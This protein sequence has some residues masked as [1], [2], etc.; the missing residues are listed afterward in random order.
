MQVLRKPFISGETRSGRFLALV[1]LALILVL[2]LF[3]SFPALHR[4]VHAEADSFDHQCVITL[5]E[6]GNLCTMDTAPAI[7]AFV[8]VLLFYLPVLPSAFSSLFHSDFL[9]AV[10]HPPLTSSEFSG[11]LF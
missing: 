5:F 4:L 9:T 7:I 6:Q 3:A 1:C 8:A 2:E 10:L 11:V